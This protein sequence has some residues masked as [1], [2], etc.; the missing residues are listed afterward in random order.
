[1]STAANKSTVERYLTAFAPADQAQIATCLTDDVVWD[2]PRTHLGAGYAVGKEDFL[3]EAA[4]APPGTRVSTTRT[5]AEGDVVVAEGSVTS[6][7]PDGAEITL[8]FCDV[9][10]LREGKIARLTS[11]LAQPNRA[12]AA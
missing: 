1:M 2:I 11:Y 12:D 6:T 4:K 9:F 10:T 7:M 8:I 3:R 5:I